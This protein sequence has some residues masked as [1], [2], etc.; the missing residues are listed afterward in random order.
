MSSGKIP[1]RPLLGFSDFFDGDDIYLGA[2]GPT[3]AGPKGNRVQVKKL[4]GGNLP[5][6]GNLPAGDGKIVASFKKIVTKKAPKSKAASPYKVTFLSAISAGKNAIDLGKKA[7]VS[8]QKTAANVK[9]GKLGPVV[10]VKATSVRGDGTVVLGAVTRKPLSPQQKAAVTKHVKLVGQ[11]LLANRRLAERAKKA[12]TAGQG[13]LSAAKNGALGVKAAF[14]PKWNKGPTRVRGYAEIG[15]EL[16]AVDLLG[17]EPDPN[18]PGF[19]TDGSIDPDMVD[20]GFVDPGLMD[21]GADSSAA[22]DAG[23]GAVLTPDGQVLYDPARDP[24]VVPMPV[25]GQILSP[26]E[27]NQSFDNVP[28]D[29]IPYD[30]SRGLPENCVGSWNAFYGGTKHE[31]WGVPSF[32]R[33]SV[34]GG[35]TIQWLYC[36]PETADKGFQ[37]AGREFQTTATSGAPSAQA[38]SA[39][40]LQRGWGPIVGNPRDPQLA[41]L[42]YAIKDGV[43]FWQGRN[44]PI[45]A[46]QEADAKIALANKR[47]IDANRAAALVVAAQ[48]EKDL[49]DRQEQQAKQDAANALAL[50]AAD[51]QT[52]VIQQQLDAQQAQLDMQ[53]QKADLDLSNMQAQQD[54]QLQQAELDMARAQAQNEA[55]QQAAL[56]EQTTIWNTWAK[57]NPQEAMAQ[58]QQQG[59]VYDDGSGGGGGYYEGGG[60]YGYDPFSDGNAGAD[61]SGY[62]PFEQ[63]GPPIYDDGGYG[64]A[65]EG[66]AYSFEGGSGEGEYGEELLEDD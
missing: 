50:S 31:G 35:K 32:L 12:Q 3:M 25:R 60:G 40:S 55:A 58:L 8:A 46:T 34:D 54:M 53:T 6:R 30:G 24:A 15:G 43:W 39:N 23:A 66:G 44:A 14:A 47:I 51:T 4:T 37:A 5:A 63:Q 38:V 62:D 11:R 64:G 10:P 1:G 27:A 19:L 57:E 7:A 61:G 13:A 9:G 65:Y 16:Y 45:W 2:A 22:M 29:G 33:G 36:S 20:P 21:P 18:N 56:I 26:E 41:S 17:A 52:Q 42:Q 28:E 48:M 49:L 59:P